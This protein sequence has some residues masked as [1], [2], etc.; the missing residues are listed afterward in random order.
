MCERVV[1]SERK[2]LKRHSWVM[3]FMKGFLE[4]WERKL[5]TLPFYTHLSVKSNFPIQNKNSIYCF[6]KIFLRHL[7]I[8]VR[9]NQNVS[10]KI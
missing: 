1:Q 2:I 10:N 4:D 7:K 9:D 6:I 3:I 5:T 8:I